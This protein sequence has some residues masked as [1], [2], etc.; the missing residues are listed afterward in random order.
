[1]LS[2]NPENVECE[3]RSLSVSSVVTVSVCNYDQAT[4]DTP[5]PSDITYTFVAELVDKNGNSLSE[6]QL[7]TVGS[8]FS[9]EILGSATDSSGNTPLS[10]D[11]GRVTVPNQLLTGGTLASKL[12]RINLNT[13]LLDAVSLKVYAYPDSASRAATGDFMLARILN[14]SAAAAQ[15]T[16]EW[17]ITCTDSADSTTL[18]DG[19]NYELSG[20]LSGTLTLSWNTERVWI[21]PL[22]LDAIQKDLLITSDESNTTASV[23]FA[24]SADT[25]LYLLQ[26]YRTAPATANETMENVNGYVWVYFASDNSSNDTTPTDP[27][28]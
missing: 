20:Q 25:S 6:A 9:L 13:E 12:Y 26:F 19:F 22:S 16:M 27:A 18:L 7:A 1:M 24:V 14:L 4:A 21:S 17:E 28:T 2:D 5:N 15:T 3:T 11:S 23:T 8:Q 10:F